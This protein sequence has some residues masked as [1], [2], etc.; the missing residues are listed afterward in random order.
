MKAITS[1]HIRKPP[2][3]LP[4]RL[5]QQAIELANKPILSFLDEHCAVQNSSTFREVDRAARSIAA[6]LQEKRKTGKPV[7]LAYPSGLE[8]VSAFC[9]CLYAGVIAV[10]A[11]LPRSHHPDER[12]P[13][14]LAN[15]GASLVLTSGRSQTIIE[16]QLGAAGI[17]VDLIATDLLPDA[18]DQWNPVR[19]GPEQLA[20]LQYTSGSTRTPSGVMVSHGNLVANLECLRE[21]WSTHPGSVGVSWLPLFHDMGLIAG[22]LEPLWVGYPTYL[23]T[24]ATFVQ[25]PLRWL[26]AITRYK[27]TIAGGP[28]FAY[29]ACVDAAKSVGIAELDLSSWQLAWNGAEPVRASTLEQFRTTFAQAGFAPE[30][31]SPGF[32]LAEATLLVTGNNGTVPAMELI[33][34]ETQLRNGHIRHC[35]ADNPRA[36]RLVSSGRARRDTSVRIVHPETRVELKSDEVGEI[37]VSGESVGKGYWQKPQETSSTFGAYTEGG[38]GPFLRTGDLGFVDNK[39][40]FVTGRLKDIIVIRGTNYYPH[41]LEHTVEACHPALRQDA[42][43]VVGIEDAGTVRIVV[44]HEVRRDSW[45]SIH[46]DE[47]VEAIRRAIA[48]KHQLALDGVVLIK[49][50]SLPKTSSGKVQRG[51]CRTAVQ[52]NTLPLVHQ[53]RRPTLQVAPIDF[54]GEPLTQPGVLER[55]LV[56]WL[57]RELS[58]NELGWKTPLMELGVDSLKAVELSNALST[59]FNYSFSATLIIDYPT[60]EALALLIREQI[61]GVTP[62]NSAV[63]IKPSL[64][65]S[66]NSS[67]TKAIELLDQD[68]LD[69]VLQ[70]TIDEVLGSGERA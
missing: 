60:V 52:D 30:S 67:L 10:P 15:C 5:R 58:L 66:D 55:Q 35:S 7:V 64:S 2:D 53:W 26:S 20:F 1:P 22:I 14:I 19:C 21:T 68:E 9:G 17:T 56:D 13:S 47:I 49:P 8:F 37:W 23:M 24:P 50:F 57:Q 29:Q 36:K 4:T 54:G 69:A 38:E 51:R 70:K 28:N 31:L 59:A 3:L 32:G 48:R 40:L 18:S 6:H 39:E 25:N 62:R 63:N 46:A 27:G 42:G 41:D 11:S 61:L 16:R 43:A 34:D 65:P 12:M 33:V 44:V 45:R